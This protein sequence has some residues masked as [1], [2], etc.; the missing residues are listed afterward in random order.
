MNKGEAPKK[1]SFLQRHKKKILFGS[2]LVGGALIG[3]RLLKRKSYQSSADKQMAHNN[4]VNSFKVGLSS[5]RKSSMSS[6]DAIATS[7]LS[8]RP[9]NLIPSSPKLSILATT[10]TR[11]R[12]RL[13]KT[14]KSLILK[15]VH[16][17]DG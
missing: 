10:R 5:R 14:N 13:P 3:H 11:P 17:I 15:Y 4:L 7:G 1:K 6:A 8:L 2:A 16:F 12:K 9:E